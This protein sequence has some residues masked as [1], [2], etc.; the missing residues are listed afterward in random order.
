MMGTR[1]IGGFIQGRDFRLMRRVHRWHP[2][3][4]MRWWMLGSSLL[5]D[6]WVWYGLAVII[7]F[8]GGQARFVTVGSSALAAG[9]GIVLVRALKRI[10]GR[11]RSCALEPHCWAK[12]LPPDQYSFPSGHT[13]TAFAIIV[14]LS[15]YYPHPLHVLIFLAVSIVVSR[16]LLGMHFLSDVLAGA[17]LGA[18]LGYASFRLFN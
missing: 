12:V 17:L 15:I 7:L 2:P 10:S 1:A 8:G 4:W 16:I 5:G 3:L 18:G 9:S 13:I 14:P 11:K 6:G